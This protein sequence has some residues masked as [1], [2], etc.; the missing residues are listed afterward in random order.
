MYSA[1]PFKFS[2]PNNNNPQFTKTYNDSNFH[3]SNSHPRGNSFDPFKNIVVNANAY[4][5]PPRQKI[6]QN[7][8]QETN[9]FFSEPKIL[10]PK[11]RFDERIKM[12]SQ[13]KFQNGQLFNE[14]VDFMENKKQCNNF[15]YHL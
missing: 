15:S 9:V 11:N 4:N 10:P 13:S 1:H 12:S 2:S 7:L 3:S 5:T 8:P 14:I 6:L